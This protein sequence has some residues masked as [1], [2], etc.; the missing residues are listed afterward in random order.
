MS[1]PKQ[2]PAEWL[3][4]YQ[5]NEAVLTEAECLWR[6][7]QIQ[8]EMRARGVPPVSTTR[9]VRRRERLD[10]EMALR[11]VSQRW[12]DERTGQGAAGTVAGSG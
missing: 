6:L 7:D 2:P 8:A 5:T 11:F 4:R 10:H 3:T 9:S 12:P 1:K